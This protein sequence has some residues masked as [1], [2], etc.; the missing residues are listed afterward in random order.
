MKRFGGWNEALAAM[1]IGLASKGRPKGLVKF[2]REDYDD[3]VSDFCFHSSAAETNATFAAY[4]EWVK[5]E[6][7]AGRSRPSGASVRNIYGTWADALR[8]VKG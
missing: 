2:T 6:L 1:G 8:S 7:A 5:Q 4:E 3:A